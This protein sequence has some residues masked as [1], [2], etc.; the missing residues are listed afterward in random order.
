MH[1][2]Q[3]QQLMNGIFCAECSN[4]HQNTSFGRIS[5]QDAIL[6]DKKFNQWG[7]RLSMR[8]S[9]AV[10]LRKLAIY[11]FAESSW[12]DLRGLECSLK[13]E[14]WGDENDFYKGEWQRRWR[15]CL[16]SKISVKDS[17]IGR[18]VEDTWLSLLFH[19]DTTQKINFE[20]TRAK[21]DEYKNYTQNPPDELWILL[22]IKSTAGVRLK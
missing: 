13:T 15:F 17:G 2:R 1:A 5:I 14:K 12:V 22:C 8:L 21:H 9:V 18:D 6:C 3:V 20:K 16:K 10:N 11:A 19:F 7:C 4:D